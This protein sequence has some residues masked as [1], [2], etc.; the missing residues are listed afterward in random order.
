MPRPVQITSPLPTTLIT[1]F[2][3]LA[4]TNILP[5]LPDAGSYNP[6]LW[7]PP[8]AGSSNLIPVHSPVVIGRVQK[9][10]VNLVNNVPTNTP[11][12][13]GSIALNRNLIITSVANVS[14]GLITLIGRDASLQVVT[15]T[16][17]GPAA[18]LS[19]TTAKKYAYLDSFACYTATAA[20][21]FNLTIGLQFTSCPIRL[22]W[23]YPN[24]SYSVSG[25]V[26]GTGCTYTVFATI[27]KVTLFS[28]EG[29]AYTNPNI[30]WKPLDATVTAATT[31]IIYSTSAMR[32]A[33]YV[34]A[35]LTDATS[36]LSFTVVQ[37]G[38]R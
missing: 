11:V 20:T 35:T 3:G 19:V 6:F 23:F 33:V 14:G 36:S 5:T 26:I 27:Q 25:D 18:G 29:I 9:N 1:G 13:T 7:N 17:T 28:N 34:D 22:D 12:P 37:Q 8:I 2:G 10:I 16:L 21:N 31:D 38:V 15:E 24:S 32:T 30:I 4:N